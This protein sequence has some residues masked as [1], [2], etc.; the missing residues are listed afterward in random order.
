MGELPQQDA[1]DRIKIRRLEEPL[2]GARQA[3]GPDD[4][5]KEL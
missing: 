5:C 3:D 4:F 2:A 1:P